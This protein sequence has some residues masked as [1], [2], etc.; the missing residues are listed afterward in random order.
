MALQALG[1][2]RAGD[3]TSTE[4]ADASLQNVE[5]PFRTGHH[6]ASKLT[7]YGCGKGLKIHE[8]PYSEAQRIY[9]E[10]AKGKLPLTK[11]EFREVIN[12]ETMVFG[13]KGLWGPQITDAERSVSEKK[14]S[15]QHMKT[16]E[17]F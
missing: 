10:Q 15:L 7:D 13:R 4:I 3:R 11:A 16:C 8:I 9:E 5:L 6:F 14:N 1:D 12:A 17:I 2:V